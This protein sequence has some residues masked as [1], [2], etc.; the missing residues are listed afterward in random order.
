MEFLIVD[1]HP[2]FAE[3]LRHVLTRLSLRPRVSIAKDAAEALEKVTSGVKYELILVDLHLPG[4]DGLGFIRALHKQNILSPI[5]V[6]S[7]TNDIQL[8]KHAMS[9][10]AMGYI[11]KSAGANDIMDGV[12]TVMSGSVYVPDY[13][14]SQINQNNSIRPSSSTQAMSLGISPR[15]L[16]VLGLIHEGLSNKQIAQQLT[17]SESTVKSHVAALLQ[18]FAVNNRTACIKEAIRLG[19]LSDEMSGSAIG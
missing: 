13:I 14:M 18:V 19:V 17:I 10:G 5:A 4:L 2:L 6:I 3:G 9:E 15:Q 12:K 7:A 1:D 8:I 16:D 11:P